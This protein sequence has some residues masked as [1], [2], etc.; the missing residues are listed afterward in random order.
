MLWALC[1]WRLRYRPEHPDLDVVVLGDAPED[2]FNRGFV[3]VKPADARRGQDAA[4]A[5]SRTRVP[6]MARSWRKVSGLPLEQ[7]ENRLL[8]LLK[9][10][11]SFC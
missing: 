3:R 2:G 11:F 5:Q 10:L 7:T 1:A 9:D 8:D 4:R 6:H